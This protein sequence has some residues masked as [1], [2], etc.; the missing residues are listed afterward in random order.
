MEREQARLWCRLLGKAVDVVLTRN[1]Q[2]SPRAGIEPGWDVAACL[3]RD[4]ECYSTG[5]PFTVEED[6]WADAKWPFAARGP[7]R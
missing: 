5:C 4:T 3:G 7:S 2:T 1:A 6:I